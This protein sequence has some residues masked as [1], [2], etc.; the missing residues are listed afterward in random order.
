MVPPVWAVVPVKPFVL[1]KQRLA[2]VLSAVYRAQ[3]AQAMFED[4]LSRL[5]QLRSLAGVLVVTADRGAGRIA[6]SAGALVLA[7]SCPRGMNAAISAAAVELAVTGAGMLVVPTD[8]PHAQGRVLEQAVNALRQVPAV[9]LAPASADG[10][11]N[12]FG[13]N[14]ANRIASRF[15]RGSFLRHC[16]AARDAGIRPIVLEDEC[17][18]LDLDTPDALWRVLT[19]G[20]APRTQ[21]VLTQLVETGHVHA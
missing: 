10:G 6:A 15:G 17:I 7:E 19:I 12:L 14:P 16:T 4:V 13:C 2:P 1:A 21:G 8:V 11:T 3:L 18:S 5:R 20:G 9:V